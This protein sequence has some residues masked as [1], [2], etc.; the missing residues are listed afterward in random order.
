[1]GIDKRASPLNSITRVKANDSRTPP[2][3][4]VAAKPRSASNIALAPLASI[5]SGPV[6]S[7][8]RRAPTYFAAVTSLPRLHV[9]LNRNTFSGSYADFTVASRPE[10][11]R[12]APRQPKV[13]HTLRRPAEIVAHHIKIGH[14]QHVPVHHAVRITHRRAV[15]VQHTDGL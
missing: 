7:N 5:T 13:N 8:T 14:R 4:G 3:L 9:P 10:S 11:R 1:M 15:Q 2:G 12:I 6:D